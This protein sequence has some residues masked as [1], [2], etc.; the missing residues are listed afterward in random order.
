MIDAS[1]LILDWA[2]QVFDLL[3]NVAR[4]QTS[5]RRL[6]SHV[7]HVIKRPYVEKFHAN[8]DRP[9][10]RGLLR[11][12]TWS[13]RADRKASEKARLSADV[14]SVAVGPSAP[15]ARLGGTAMVVYASFPDSDAN[16]AEAINAA[17]AGRGKA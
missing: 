12:E 4:G 3:D 15:F 7:E 14:R 5:R 10:S 16:T 2:G 8:R 6:G 13:R 17:L 11:K 9:S 1:P